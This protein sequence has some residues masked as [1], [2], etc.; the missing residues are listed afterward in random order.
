MPCPDW[1]LVKAG[2]ILWQRQIQGSKTGQKRLPLVQ[3]NSLSEMGT[4]PHDSITSAKM[5]FQSQ[6]QNAERSIKSKATLDLKKNYWLGV[7]Y[8]KYSSSVRAPRI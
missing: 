3:G 1:V 5:Q 4:G 8:D 6:T 7:K 2:R